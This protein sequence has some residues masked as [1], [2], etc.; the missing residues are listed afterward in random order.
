M[1]GHTQAALHSHISEPIDVMLSWQWITKD[2]SF[3]ASFSPLSAIR[4]AEIILRAAAAACGQLE[5]HI[6]FSEGSLSLQHL[7]HR[8]HSY[9]LHTEQIKS[10]SEHTLNIS[11]T[12]LSIQFD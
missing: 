7:P 10:F 5:A 2:S 11:V 4:L 8:C 6:I 1:T 3:T 9:R 12:A